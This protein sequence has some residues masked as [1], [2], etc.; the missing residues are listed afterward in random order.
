[1]EP[2][3]YFL[4]TWGCQMNVLDSRYLAGVL[5]SRGLREVADVR[6]ADVVLLN[7]C[8]VREKAVHKVLSRLGELRG[9]RRE[10]GRPRIVGLCGCV[11]EQ[12]GARLLS[13]SDVLSFVVGP[14]HI[15]HLGSAIDAASGGLRATFTGFEQTRGYETHLVARTQAARQFVTVVHGCSQHC[16]FCVVPYTRGHEASRSLRA[17]VMEVADLASAGAKEVTL[18]GQT[19]NA[20]RCP[21]TG[22]DLADLL[23]AIAEI[24]GLW[25]LQFLTSHP[26]FFTDKL[27]RAMREVPRMGSYLHM[28]FQSGADRILERMHRRYTREEYLDLVRRIR[29]V[30]PDVS[31]STDVIVGFPGEE[32]RD[33]LDTLELVEEVRFAQLYGF[34]YSPRP[35]TPAAAYPCRVDRKRAAARLQELFATQ[36]AIQLELNLGRVGATVDVLVDGPARRGGSQW[37]GRGDDNRVVNFPAWRGIA[38]GQLASV[39]I[40]GATA[41]ALLGECQNQPRKDA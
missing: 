30:L 36:T 29:D 9:C 7:T 4:E 20:Y 17:I 11:A 25:Q 5:E 2:R 16:T 19:V 1:M 39:R 3:T 14:G 37:Q 24:D 21:E 34:I 31:L 35:R 26:K 23:R 40:T 12:E 22:A 27:I 10:T 41:H 18:L 38:E 33:F 8:A 13:R 6:D 15:A 28:P 32:E